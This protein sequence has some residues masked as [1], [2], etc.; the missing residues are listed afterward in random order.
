MPEP[1]PGCHAVADQIIVEGI[2]HSIW[3]TMRS[4]YTSHHPGILISTSSE[5]QGAITG[6][7]QEL[8][9]IPAAIERRALLQ[10]KCVRHPSEMT[11]LTE[12]HPAVLGEQD[13]LTTEEI[14]AML[15]W[16]SQHFPTFVPATRPCIAIVD[17]QHHVLFIG[18]VDVRP[19]CSADGQEMTPST[20]CKPSEGD[21]VWRSERARVNTVDS[22][23]FAVVGRYFCDRPVLV[24]AVRIAIPPLEITC[25]N[26]SRRLVM[27]A[28]G[29]S[30]EERAARFSTEPPAHTETDLAGIVAPDGWE[31]ILG[32]VGEGTAQQLRREAA[33]WGFGPG[34]HDGCGVQAP[35]EEALLWRVLQGVT[36]AAQTA[37]LAGPCCCCLH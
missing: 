18:R 24:R 11:R 16:A 6:M 36:A 25:V 17:G 33:A 4:L 29:V 27:W 2:L 12:P 35:G 34:R 9:A 20:S 7:Q 5:R 23:G 30:S 32:G 26:E 19:Q 1:F 22:P 14:G 10:K 31:Y 13:N 3:S 28:D 21:G 15:R 8:A 37:I